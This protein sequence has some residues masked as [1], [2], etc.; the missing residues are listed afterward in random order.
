MSINSTEQVEKLQFSFD[1]WREKFLR[2]ILYGTAAIGLVALIPYAITEPNR[3]FVFAAVGFY[4]TLLL[5]T[6]L[7]M[8]YWLRA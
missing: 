4:I 2:V 7:R 3:S 1:Q 5:F 6:F 8:P